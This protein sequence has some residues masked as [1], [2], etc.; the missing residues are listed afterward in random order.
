MIGAC[1]QAAGLILW[2]LVL[3]VLQVALWPVLSKAFGRFAYPISY[4]LSFL[5]FG[6]ISWY[7]GLLHLP[8]QAAVIPFLF[9]IG[10]YA[11]TGWYTREKCSGVWK[12]DAAFLLCFAFMTEI[13]FFNPMISYAEKFMDHAFLASVM[14]SPVVAPADPWFAGGTLATYYYL[15]HWMMGVTGILSGTPSSVAFNLIL[16]TVFANAAVSLYAVGHL[17]LTRFRALPVMALF[18]INPSFIVQVISGADAHGVLW[19][20]TR[21]IADT[22]N[23]YPL[24][25]FLW[26]D[27]HAHVIS[28]FCQ[29][30]FIFLMLYILK[31]WGGLT[32]RSRWICLGAAAL[33]LGVMPGINSWDVLVYAPLLLAV[34]AIVW[35]RAKSAEVHDPYPWRLFLVCPV[36]SVLLFAPYYLMLTTQGVAGIGIVPVPSSVPEFM[37]VYGFFIVMFWCATLRD[38]WENTR[39]LI[40]L[41]PFVLTGYVAAGLAAVPLA[42]LI[43]RRRFLPAEVISIFG[44][45]VLI[46]SELFY[47]IDGMGDVYY[48][49]NTV[50][51]F[52]LAAWMMMSAGAFIWL[53]EWL[54][55]RFR[56]RSLPVWAV[57]A[58]AGA[59]VLLLIC[60]PLAIPDLT[61]GYGGKTLDGLAWVDTSHPGDAAAV[62]Y[63]SILPEN[64]T[65]LEAEGGDYKY[66]SRM[67]SFTGIP[68]VIGMPFHE[69]MWRGNDAGISQR[70]ADV[71][72]IYEDPS[73]SPSLLS[74]Y[75]VDYLVLGDTENERYSVRLPEDMLEE[76]FSQNGT[77]IFRVMAPSA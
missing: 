60:A 33:S 3:K 26:G 21:T 11:A 56:D 22:I 68:T 77:I 57:R 45:A 12:W 64:V 18:L 40:V 54:T 43:L 67:S 62:A 8:V 51:K 4:P 27:P 46:F 53:G 52:G 13:R 69:T 1:A 61:Y 71:Q 58:G 59:I 75:G 47:L 14:R 42:A 34:G 9:I 55:E 25:S 23:E 35:Y 41:V 65:I 37:L 5:L 44:L 66:Y 48:R 20:S 2:L 19:N 39:L 24:F 32:E 28:L 15:G 10:Y 29:A 72:M 63:L 31:E 74:L 30:L 16:P 7:L 6:G 49:M 70:A 50:F 36:V 38:I 76:V 73:R 17:L